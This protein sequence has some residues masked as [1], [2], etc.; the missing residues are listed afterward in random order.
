M[1]NQVASQSQ[2]LGDARLLAGLLSRGLVRKPVQLPSLDNLFP[3]LLSRLHLNVEQKRFLV[4]LA[5]GGAIPTSLLV[6][7]GFAER[8]VA[9]LIDLFPWLFLLREE[10]VGR[11]QEDWEERLLFLTLAHPSYSGALV[12]HLALDSKAVVAGVVD[13][14]AGV[15]EQASAWPAGL[16]FFYAS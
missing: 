14:L 12:G 8:D 9:Q 5:E 7:S 11:L 16:D 15:I 3:F 10:V 13:H 2:A 1:W 6:A 4:F